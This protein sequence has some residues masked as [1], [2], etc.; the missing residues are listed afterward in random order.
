MIINNHLKDFKEDHPKE[1]EI[2]EKKPKNI[3]K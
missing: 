3:I 1:F 2:L